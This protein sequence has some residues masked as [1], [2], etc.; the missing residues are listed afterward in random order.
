MYKHTLYRNH[1]LLSK[2]IDIN[3]KLK[4]FGFEPVIFIKGIPS[5]LANKKYLGQRPMSDIDLL[6]PAFN[7]DFQKSI[8]F[9]K[10]NNYSIRS[11]GCKELTITDPKGTE[12]DIH[13]YLNN[14]ALKKATAKKLFKHSTAIS[15]QGSTLTLPC[16]EHRLALVILHGVFSSTL[17]YDARWVID[18]L[19]LLTE[20]QQLDADI[21]LDFI[22]DF[23]LPAKIKYGID[24]IV[25]HCPPELTINQKALIAISQR[26]NAKNPFLDFFYDHKPRPNLEF[27]DNK[28]GSSWIKSGIC[29]HIIEPVIIAKNNQV[30]LLEAI[31]LTVQFPPPSLFNIIKLIVTKIFQRIVYSPPLL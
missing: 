3:N 2:A 27:I 19:E 30:N 11:F 15:Y 26:I 16:F 28:K 8:A 9:I 1:L 5:I 4:L 6:V 14:G 10:E 24:L 18:T 23:T 29:T 12:Y 31:G 25:T 20:Q 7:N 17:T 22:C 21:F 13:W